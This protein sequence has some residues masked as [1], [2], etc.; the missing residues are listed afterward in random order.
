MIYQTAKD[1]EEKDEEGM[2][3]ETFKTFADS[4]PNGAS[5]L[6]LTSLQLSV[7][8]ARSESDYLVITLLISYLPVTFVCCTH[9]TSQV[10]LQLA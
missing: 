5:Q 3:E 9:I 6:E 7:M 8:F 10:R 2:W 1:E 4:K